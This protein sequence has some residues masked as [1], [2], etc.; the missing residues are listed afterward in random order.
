V[1]AFAGVR[2]DEREADREEPARS[3]SLPLPS[4]IIERS[5]LR[6]VTIPESSA[7]AQ[8]RPL[9]ATLAAGW[10]DSVEP[11]PPR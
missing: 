3:R 4:N 2:A 10:V 7:L 5:P 11:R 1:S 8:N 9:T 6:D